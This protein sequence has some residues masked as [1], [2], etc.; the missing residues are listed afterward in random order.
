[1]KNIDF[2]KIN[3]SRIFQALLISLLALFLRG[4]LAVNGPVEYDEPVYVDAA[5]LYSSAM[6][7]QDWDQIFNSTYNIEH[8]IFNKLLYSIVLLFLKP[9]G[10]GIKMPFD[11][12]L[13][14]LPHFYKLLAMRLISVLAGTA[15]VFILSLINPIAGLAF[16]IHTFAIKYSSIIYLEAV[17][18]LASLVS[19]S[20]IHKAFD[21]LSSNKD[22]PTL[23][24]LALSSFLT[25]IAIASKYLYGVVALAIVVGILLTSRYSK[26][27]TML[28]LA[29]WGGACL[30][31]FL[32]LNPILWPSPISRM[33]E[34]IQFSIN[35]SGNDPVVNQKNYPTWQPI[36]WL[37]L[38]IPHH[39]QKLLPFFVRPGDYFILADTIIFILAVIGFPTL[40]RRTL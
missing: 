28:W 20:A 2:K 11:T 7:A 5:I 3:S 26:Q 37:L 33:M 36:H 30:L 31:F 23:S 4:Y 18:L 25:G 17:P 6:R 22:R 16:A 34:S 39:S 9:I 10:K 1:M 19:L 24:W 32:L 35:Y 21:Q 27:R 40:I 8:P 38:S 29:V 13:Y 14:T 12:V 15:S